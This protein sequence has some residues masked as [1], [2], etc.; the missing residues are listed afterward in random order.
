MVKKTL[1]HLPCKIKNNPQMKNYSEMTPKEKVFIGFKNHLSEWVAYGFVGSLLDDMFYQES[2]T[3]D[4]T[5]DTMVN[6]G[7]LLFKISRAKTILE[8]YEVMESEWGM[9]WGTLNEE[10]WNYL[11]GK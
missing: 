1:V 11:E 3:K 2:N 9:D 6:L 5:I 10:F 4:T 7:T 8:L